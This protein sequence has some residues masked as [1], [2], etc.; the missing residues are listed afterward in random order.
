MLAARAYRY[1]AFLLV[2]A[3]LAPGVEAAGLGV[4]VHQI[5]TSQFPK[6]RAFAS[7]A[8]DQGVRIAD[9]EQDPQ[10]FELLEDGQPVA[11]FQ[12]EPIIASQ[13]PVA[14]ALA[15]DVSGSMNDEGK[16][17]A[18]KQA[19][20]AFIDTMGAKDGAAL[21]S[22][23]SQVKTVQPYTGDKGALKA[24]VA[25]LKA[26]G[27]T[28]L[29]DAIAEAAGVMGGV[30]EQRKVIILL[31]DGE[32][33]TSKKTNVDQ[34]I[35]A[36]RNAKAPVFAVGLGSGVKRDVLDKIASQT[37]GQAV[38]VAKGDQLRQ[39]FLN[40][41]DQLRRQYVLTYTSKVPADNKQHELT[42]RAKYRGQT[43]EAKGQFIAKPA[44]A[45]YD[46]KGISDVSQVTGTQRVEV[47]PV[48]GVIQQVELLVDE[49]SRGTATAAPFAIQW[50]TSK[51]KPGL[52]KVIVRVKD[53]AGTTTDRQFVVEVL[54]PTPTAAPTAAPTPVPTAT[55][56]AAPKTA[57]AQPTPT[58]AA[59][60][61][62]MLYA[63]IGIG[64]LVVLGVV[65]GAILLLRR[66]PAPPP[67]PAPV[68]PAFGDQTDPMGLPVVKGPAPAVAPAVP[69][70]PAGS[71]MV[72]AGDGATV[73][74]GAEATVVG[75]V[76]AAPPRPRARLH[77]VH[78]GV[79]RDVFVDQPETILGREATNPVAIKDPL[80]S[81]R[82]ARITIE[83]GE[84]WIEDLKSLNGTR[85]NGEVITRRKLADNDQIKIGD[86]IVTFTRDTTQSG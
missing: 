53:A 37:G 62:A 61:N 23:A 1:V 63:A 10:A 3:L 79:E 77:I 11:S 29:Y 6:V 78:L 22:F 25:G 40:L 5:D 38:Y 43:G 73:V 27:A 19:A 60:D 14:V 9:L 57:V 21:I 47:T 30:K 75:S 32:D 70:A 72:S 12:A 24:G 55:A 59:S 18:A 81:R 85:V 41:G 49:Q 50:D 7:V 26:E 35:A 83:D 16:I 67:A 45:A 15:M 13:E 56:A 34:A 28:L 4:T 42:V 44:P 51:E 68:K 20:S 64:A 17:D 58:P 46:V 8:N 82:H 86:A 69:A 33:E 36:A 52:H 84:F 2:L 80:A 76:S 74:G 54:A 39:V 31:T 71:T 65:V 48:T 66:K